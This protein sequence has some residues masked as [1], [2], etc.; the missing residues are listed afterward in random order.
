MSRKVF[1][2]S[3]KDAFLLLRNNPPVLEVVWR[4]G[5]GV[6]SYGLVARIFASLLPVALIWITKLI[7]DII[8]HFL[9]AHEPVPTRLWWLVAAEFGLAVFTSVLARTIDY[10]DTL[11]AEKY[12]R[13]VS[14]RS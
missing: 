11:L 5:P 1:G 14:M 4:S 9:S 7:I 10:S 3:W 2:V 13:H 6:V 12:T 8:Q